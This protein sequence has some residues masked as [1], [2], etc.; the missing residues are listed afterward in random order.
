MNSTRLE[1]RHAVIDYI[2]MFYSCHRLHSSLGHMA[3][4]DFEMNL[5]LKKIA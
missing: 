3:P 1:A 5:A 4:D 2:E